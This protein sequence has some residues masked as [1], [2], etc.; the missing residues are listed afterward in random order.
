MRYDDQPKGTIR[1]LNSEALLKQIR[2]A[3]YLMELDTE[4]LLFP[5]RF[6]SGLSG[7]VNHKMIELHG[8]WDSQS[9]HIRGTFTG[10]Y[11]SASALLCRDGE[12]P[13]LR[14]KAEYVVEEIRKCQLQNGGKWAFPIPEKYLYS[15]R[16][17]KR[18]WAPFYVCHKVMMGLL[19]MGRLLDNQTA[20]EILEG[21]TQWFA[22]FLKDVSQE[23]LSRMMNTEETGGIMEFWAQLY[24]ITRDERH[25]E[26][27]RKLERKELFEAM[28]QKKDVLTNM[29]ANA[30]IPEIHGAAAAYGVT[31]EKRYL[32]IAENYWDLAV[33][34]RGMYATG[35]QTS[36]EV[37]TPI[38]RQAARLGE[39]NQE[40]CVVYNMIR[41][42]DYLFRY[43]GKAEYGDYIERNVINGL[44]AQGFYQ[45]RTLDTRGESPYPE[46]GVVSYYLPLMAGGQ[47][48][49]GK[50]TE[51]FWCCHCTA[52]QANARYWE[53]IYYQKGETI[54]VN[55]YF[56][57]HLDTS[58]NGKKLT[59][60]LTQEDA[61]VSCIEI[62]DSTILSDERP[63]YDSY[64]IR[65]EAPETE[66]EI[67]FRVP[68]WISGEVSC[69][70]DG[71]PCQAKPEQGFLKLTGT[72]KENQIRIV[73][74]RKLHTWPLPDEKDTV[75]FLDGPDVLAGIV[76]EERILYGDKENPETMLQ[77]HNERVWGCWTKEYKT[78]DQ[79]NGFYFKPIREIGTEK[80][81]VY[82]PVKRQE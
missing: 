21:C 51:D 80:Y 74:P 67:A 7:S 28:L 66:A 46:T 19:D 48:R 65:V 49:W 54:C 59:L 16:D 36:G 68:W 42:A 77:P 10:H 39:Q 73:F 1:L 32:E 30:T 35:G 71:K 17:G 5:F 78:K 64:L 81:T 20:F 31:G 11:L 2:D 61:E 40:H 6:E 29:H 34:K 24:G 18:F 50:K 79:Q 8:G 45:A 37:W 3:E 44:F 4:N 25:L 41:L 47:K 26:L 27:M 23:T 57:S 62:N 72:W 43:T 58:V 76:P 13:M 82:F 53:Y 15:L 60:E 33:T 69:E 63:K 9:S 22:E 12:Y 52:V 70:I 38:M 14:V 75:A 56:P 55:Q